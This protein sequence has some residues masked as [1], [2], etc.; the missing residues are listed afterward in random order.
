MDDDERRDPRERVACGFTTRLSPLNSRR[1][2]VFAKCSQKCRPS[3]KRF[4]DP[5]R[6][7]LI[8]SYKL[9][10]NIIRWISEN[11]LVGAISSLFNL[12]LDDERRRE[13]YSSFGSEKLSSIFSKFR[14]PIPTFATTYPPFE[15][16]TKRIYIFHRS[17]MVRYSR[18]SLIDSATSWIAWMR[19]KLGNFGTF[20]VLVTMVIFKTRQTM[21]NCGEGR[22]W[23]IRGNSDPRIPNKPMI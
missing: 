13:K 8:M 9:T 1:T 18:R 12:K 2:Q 6:L 17:N 11:S 19:R 5:G 21:K 15:K 7:V 3:I 20:R 16:K 23:D 14:Y 4:L 22:L 10:R